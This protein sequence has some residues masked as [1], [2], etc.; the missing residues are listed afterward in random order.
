MFACNTPTIVEPEGNW[1]KNDVGNAKE[2][3]RKKNKQNYTISPEKCTFCPNSKG[4]VQQ[5]WVCALKKNKE[6]KTQGHTFPS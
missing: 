1:F 2:K 4:S 6:K 5:K 3:K